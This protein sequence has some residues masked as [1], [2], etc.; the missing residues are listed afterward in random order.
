MD[1]NGLMCNSQTN[2]CNS[3]INECTPGTRQC[4]EAFPG[5]DT[6]FRVCGSNGKWD[7]PMSCPAE[8]Y[9]EDS[10]GMCVNRLFTDKTCFSWQVG[11]TRCAP[12]EFF[13]TTI[14]VCTQSQVAN[15]YLWTSQMSCNPGANSELGC[16]SP[17]SGLAY[18]KQCATPGVRTCISVQSWN[19]CQNDYTYAQASFCNYPAEVCVSGY[20]E[21]NPNSNQTNTTSC[22]LNDERC[23]PN[24]I[25]EKCKNI[26]GNTAFY[27]DRA[28]ASNEYC[29]V[30]GSNPILAVCRVIPAGSSSSGSSSGSGGGMVGSGGGFWDDSSSGNGECSYTDWQVI[31]TANFVSSDG[32]SCTNSTLVRYCV[33]SNQKTDD[34]RTETEFSVECT[35]ADKCDYV[36]DK[37]EKFTDANEEGMCRTCEREV[38]VYTCQ[39]S[40]KADYTKTKESVSCGVY[41]KCEAKFP[42]ANVAEKG[43]FDTLISDWAVALGIIILLIIAAIAFLAYKSG[44][45]ENKKDGEQGQQEEQQEQ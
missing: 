6:S 42:T 13:P 11:D 32:S 18:C 31:S 10:T 2:I 29:E 25:I 27:T 15:Q 36:Y 45:D 39:P 17:Y 14:E 8:K 40:G 43:W 35:Q 23:A 41:S 33:L 19:I 28:C 44:D 30:I 20:C 9:C 16:F 5:D 1:C 12:S 38:Y 26:S 4:L 22:T 34:S 3:P 37:T 21:L 24:G 7:A